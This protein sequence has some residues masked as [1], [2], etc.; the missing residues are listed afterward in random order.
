MAGMNLERLRAGILGCGSFAQQHAR[1]LLGL[2]DQAMLVACCDRHPERAAR[3]SQ[4]FTGGAAAVYTDPRALVE[5]AGLDLLVISL[6][7]YGHAGEVELAAQQGIHL[8][9]EKP[10]ALSSERA[11]RMVAAAEGAGIK[12]QVGFKFRFGAAVEALKALIEAGETGRVGLFSARYFANALHAPWWRAREKSGGQ[13]VEQG[14]HLLDLARFLVGEASTVYSRQ[15]NLFHQATPGYTSE[16]TSATVVAFKNNALGVIYVTNGAIP[17]R[18]I[19]D[20]RLVSQNLT[21]DFSDANHATFHFTAGPTRA[22]LTIASDRDL[23]RHQ[24]LDLIAAIRT[25]GETRTPI[26]EGALALDLA[27]GALESAQTH[28]EVR[29]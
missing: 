20:Y 18:W 12:T 9:V 26:R 13:L 21:A 7:P 24:L 10:I 5:R 6:P 29:L 17:N 1:T 3:L 25:N 23:L 16:D 15:E 8:L 27:L 2:S 28:A 19:N 14:I 4:Q 22:P 11:W